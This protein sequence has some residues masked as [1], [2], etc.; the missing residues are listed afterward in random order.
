[1]N[2]PTIDQLEGP[3]LSMQDLALLS[4]SAV[5]TLRFFV[6]LDGQGG[7]LDWFDEAA[8]RFKTYLDSWDV[9]PA[10]RQLIELDFQKMRL[11]FRHRLA[12]RLRFKKLISA[13]T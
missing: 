10:A 1:M 9:T 2:E 3:G 8:A 4:E 13:Y 7:D 12:E 11:L 6:A 5:R